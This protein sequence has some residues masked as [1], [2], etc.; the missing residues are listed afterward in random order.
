MKYV[1]D[2]YAGGRYAMIHG[3]EGASFDEMFKSRV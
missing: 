1:F 3:L 2:K